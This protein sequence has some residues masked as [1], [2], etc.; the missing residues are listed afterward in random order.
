MSWISIHII[1]I[2]AQSIAYIDLYIFCEFVMR[3]KTVSSA[4]SNSYY[5]IHYLMR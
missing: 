2:H 5:L 3:G 4:V 1:H